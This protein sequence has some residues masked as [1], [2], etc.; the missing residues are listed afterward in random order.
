MLSKKDGLGVVIEILKMRFFRPGERPHK[1]SR[2]LVAIARDVLSRYSFS[3]RRGQIDDYDLVQIARVCLKGKLGINTCIKLCENL[4]EAIAVN[5][6]YTFDCPELLNIIA[7]AYP[8]IFLDY[9]TEKHQTIVKELRRMFDTA[10]DKAHGNP[11]N[12]IPDDD[13]IAWCEKNQDLRYTL[14]ASAIIPFSKSAKAGKWE[15][16]AIALRIFEKAPDLSKI[17]QSFSEAILPMSWSGSLANLFQEELVLFE[18]LYEHH[19]GEI[20]A[21]SKLQYSALVEWIGKERESEAR[22]DRERNERFE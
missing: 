20:R 17:L 3:E 18:S 16:K 19:N 10:P 12:Q 15:W 6:V 2:N 9:F 21:W 22:F 14:I 5:R 4:S 13:I 7:R 1:H 8:L 11:L